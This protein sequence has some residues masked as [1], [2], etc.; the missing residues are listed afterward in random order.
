LRGAVIGDDRHRLVGQRDGAE[1]PAPSPAQACARGIE[2]DLLAR[3]DAIGKA[4]FD[5]GECD[6]RG[7]EDAALRRRPGKLGDGEERLACQRRGG[8]DGGAAAVDE[9]ERA[10]RAAAIFGDALGVSEGE[11]CSDARIPSPLRGGLYT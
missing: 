11:E 1:P 2:R 9:Q 5:L 10:R 7:A 6:R 4:P 3:R 8:I